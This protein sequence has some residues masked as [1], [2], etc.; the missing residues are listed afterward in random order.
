MDA[1]EDTQ[2]SHPPPLV[3]VSE[4]HVARVKV[5]SVY[6]AAL[7]EKV[8]IKKNYEYSLEVIS[9]FQW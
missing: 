4:T 2:H 5:S 9:P 7:A 6:S 3:S 8:I 1:E